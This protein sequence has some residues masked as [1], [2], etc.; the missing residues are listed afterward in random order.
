VGG[1]ER[2]GGSGGEMTQTLYAHMNKI[3]KKEE[4]GTR[5]DST[6]LL[7]ISN[8]QKFKNVF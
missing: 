2:A 6:L 5:W 3:L 4:R 7:F 1:R 8:H